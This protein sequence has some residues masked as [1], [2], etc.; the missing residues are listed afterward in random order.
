MFKLLIFIILEKK[1]R[2]LINTYRFVI[3]REIDHKLRVAL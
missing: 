3:Y 1:D 2:F